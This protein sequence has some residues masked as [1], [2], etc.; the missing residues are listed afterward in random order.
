MLLE[1][2]ASNIDKIIDD[3]QY[4][5]NNLKFEKRMTMEASA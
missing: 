5:Q 3:S 1:S 4:D 2:K